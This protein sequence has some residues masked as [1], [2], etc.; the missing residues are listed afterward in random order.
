MMVGPSIR[1][2]DPE[3]LH[4]YEPDAVAFQVTERPGLGPSSRM[5]FVGH[6]PGIIRPFLQWETKL[7]DP[8]PWNGRSGLQMGIL[9]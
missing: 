4:L 3:I 5:G 9:R 8:S 1:T 2:E 7:V 6:F